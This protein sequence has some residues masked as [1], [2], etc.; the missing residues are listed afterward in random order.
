MIENLNSGLTKLQLRIANA[1]T[2]PDL[3]WALR[4]GGGG[5]FG[6]VVQATLKAH[7][8]PL[9]TGTLWWV[10]TTNSGDTKSVFAPTAYLMGQLPDLNK[11]GVQ[12][13]FYIY[14]NAI[15][16]IFFLAGEDSGEDKAKQTW[17]PLL[18]KLSRYPGMASPI[19]EHVELPNYKIFFDAAFGPLE[20]HGSMGQP[21]PAPAVVPASAKPLF[22]RGFMRRAQEHQY[23][24]DLVK[25]HG[26]GGDDDDDAPMAA[27]KGPV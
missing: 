9:I 26:P 18:E 6:V 12:G 8:T 17:A 4:G 25:R 13:Y 1:V 5:T 16:G 23:E 21:A 19:Q 24:S 10:N 3:F 14:P 2:N 11:K 22:T 27:N 7:P 15:Q 20:T